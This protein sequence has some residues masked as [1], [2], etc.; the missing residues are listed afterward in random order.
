LA[1]TV[2]IPL[3]SI[4]QR[5]L[6]LVVLHWYWVVAAAILLKASLASALSAVTTVLVL[7]QQLPMDRLQHRLD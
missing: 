6:P 3:A 5:T 1:A 2:T 7:I 4:I